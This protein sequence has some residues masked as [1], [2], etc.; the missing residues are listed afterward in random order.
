MIAVA[1]LTVSEPVYAKQ[2]VH[3]DRPDEPSRQGR[4]RCSR[5]KWPSLY[6]CCCPQTQ[7]QLVLKPNTPAAVYALAFPYTD[8]L[9]VRHPA[10]LNA[11]PCCAN[12]GRRGCRC[13]ESR[14]SRLPL[15]PLLDE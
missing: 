6:P 7:A 9:A 8:F 14:P 4:C 5:R 13:T 2:A 10:A 15:L 3:V 1:P 12:G 11:A